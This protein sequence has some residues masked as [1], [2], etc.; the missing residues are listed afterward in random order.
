MDRELKTTN[1]RARKSASEARGKGS[2]T[3]VAV[4]VVAHCI[5]TTNITLPTTCD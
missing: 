1:S 4:A 3:G 5:F 2:N